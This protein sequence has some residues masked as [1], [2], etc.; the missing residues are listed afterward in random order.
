[1]TVPAKSGFLAGAIRIGIAGVARGDRE[2]AAD[3]V[4]EFLEIGFRHSFLGKERRP[5]AR[6]TFLS[7]YIQ[8]SKWG[9][10]IPSESGELNSPS[11]EVISGICD[12]AGA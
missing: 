3:E 4:G 11:N 8:N 9:G 12:K 1:M 5:A 2:I 7:P 6:R 10:A